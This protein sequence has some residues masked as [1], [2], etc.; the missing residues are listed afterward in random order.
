MAP[1]LLIQAFCL[2]VFP[3]FL[4]F[5]SQLP[6][7]SFMGDRH[8]CAVGAALG[9]QRQAEQPQHPARSLCEDITSFQEMKWHYRIS[10]QI[11][12]F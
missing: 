5:V 7:L 12:N 8:R 4:N 10:E 9:E 6:S 1:S 2:L 3:F 11:V